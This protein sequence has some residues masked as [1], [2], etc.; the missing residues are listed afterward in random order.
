[1]IIVTMADLSDAPETI[2]EMVQ[3]QKTNRPILFAALVI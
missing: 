3:K 2:N 1:M